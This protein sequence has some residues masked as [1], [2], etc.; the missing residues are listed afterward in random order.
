MF[1]LNVEQKL[2]KAKIHTAITAIKI[3]NLLWVLKFVKS[4][5]KSSSKFKGFFKSLS[6][7][8]TLLEDFLGSFCIRSKAVTISCKKYKN[9]NNLSIID[10]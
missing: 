6:S 7:E 10:F 9:V 8:V 4:L 3:L 1:F 2:K 5:S